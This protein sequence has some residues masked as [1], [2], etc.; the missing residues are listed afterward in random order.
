MRTMNS[1]ILTYF[2]NASYIEIIL[3]FYICTWFSYLSS[4]Y[5]LWSIQ[6]YLR[7]D[8]F[9]FADIEI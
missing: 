6:V 5:L 7:V 4:Q 8:M 1:G 3:R 2:H 9:V